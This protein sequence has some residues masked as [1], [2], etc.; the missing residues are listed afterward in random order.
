VT[1]YSLPDVLEAAHIEPYL[2]TASNH[3]E[4]GLLLR[5]DIHILFDLNFIAVNPDSL[6]IVRS[7]H[8]IGYPEIRD[9]LIVSTFEP[10]KS[11]LRERWRQFQICESQ[12]KAIQPVADEV[13]SKT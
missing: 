4:N 1:G 9:A 7:I 5:A 11:A 8:V 3:V 2:G 13:A 12:R 6:T 10:S